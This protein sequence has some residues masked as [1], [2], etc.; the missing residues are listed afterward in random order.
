VSNFDQTATETR[1]GIGVRTQPLWTRYVSNILFQRSMPQV[2]QAPDAGRNRGPSKSPR[3]CTPHLQLRRL[4]S[5][6]NQDHLADAVSAAVDSTG[7]L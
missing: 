3:S 6:E 1:G 2:R 7:V 5:C 4:R